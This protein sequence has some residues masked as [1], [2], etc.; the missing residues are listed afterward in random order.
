MVYNTLEK[1]LE[2]II[3]NIQ[4]NLKI[5]VLSRKS[6]K[7]EIRI[8]LKLLKDVEEK[9]KRHMRLQ[10]TLGRGVKSAPPKRRRTSQQQKTA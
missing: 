6:E 10:L 4:K 2:F 8:W 1:V 5:K 7:E 3:I 9:K